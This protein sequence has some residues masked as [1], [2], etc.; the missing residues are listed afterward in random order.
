MTFYILSNKSLKGCLKMNGA[1]LQQSHSSY[2]ITV[3]VW[4]MEMKYSVCL[5][6]DKFVSLAGLSTR[7]SRQI[8]SSPPVKA[9]FT[10]CYVGLHNLFNWKFVRL[11]LIVFWWRFLSQNLVL[12]LNFF[13]HIS[14]ICCVSSAFRLKSEVRVVLVHHEFCK[15]ALLFL[16]SILF[17]LIIVQCI[18][19]MNIFRWLVFFSDQQSKTQRCWVYYQGKLENIH[20]WEAVRGKFW[21]F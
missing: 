3:S 8:P 10:P 4:R 17:S 11:W 14:L 18:K 1:A 2:V 12:K 21:A 19:W 15:A 6:L 16:L 20:I 13:A 5:S 7:Q 9:Q